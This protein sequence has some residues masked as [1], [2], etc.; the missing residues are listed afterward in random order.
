M[1]N[2]LII[3]FQLWLLHCLISCGPTTRDKAAV[4]AYT[5]EIVDSVQ[6]DFLGSLSLYAVHSVKELFL[7][8]EYRQK[9]LILTDRKGDILSTFAEP[10]D[11]P[12]SYG[13]TA[14]FVGDRIV[15]LGPQKL[16]FY[17]LDF[18]FIKSYN[19]PY[20]GKG[21]LYSGYDRL[22]KG[23]I[24]DE[25]HLVAFTGGPQHPAATKQEDYYTHFNTFDLIHPDTGGFSPIVSLHPKSR[26]FQGRLLIIY[27]RC[28]RWMKT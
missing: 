12:T 15:V 22:Q 6:V 27:G 10:S 8:H 14:S 13:S 17:D 2:V 23:E 21:M 5:L 3:L 7:F 26:Y 11:A 24:N 25:I 28:F 19:K 18:N 20:A 4:N 9:T 16:V 1:K